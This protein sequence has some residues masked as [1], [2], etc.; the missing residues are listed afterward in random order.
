MDYYS[1]ED[2]DVS[3]LFIT[4]EAK[5]NND[6]SGENVDSNAD[7]FLRI[8]TDDF[9]SPCVSLFADNSNPK[10][11]DISDHENAFSTTQQR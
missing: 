3:D 1:L 2:E 8:A 7:S 5:E 10:Y 6:E 9:Q 4:Q 11:S